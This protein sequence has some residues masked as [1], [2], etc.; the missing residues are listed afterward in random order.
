MSRIARPM[1][2][3]GRINARISTLNSKAITATAISTATIAEL[4]NWLNGAYAL[5]LSIDRPMYQSADGRPVIGVNDSSR[6]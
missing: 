5:S 2:V 1:S 4:R 3:S 6:C